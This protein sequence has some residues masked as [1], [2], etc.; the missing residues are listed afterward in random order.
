MQSPAWL[1]RATLLPY[2]SICSTPLLNI[3]NHRGSAKY[4][5]WTFSVSEQAVIMKI[6]INGLN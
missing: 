6:I 5:R 4:I 2:Y 3:S 1:Q